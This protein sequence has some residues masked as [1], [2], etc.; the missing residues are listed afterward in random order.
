MAT[1][2]ASQ[3]LA[4]Q[5]NAFQRF[6]LAFQATASTAQSFNWWPLLTP[7]LYGVVGGAT[8][9]YFSE[10]LGF[11]DGDPWAEDK[12]AKGKKKKK[13]KTKKGS[14]KKKKGTGKKM[15]LEGEAVEDEEEDRVEAEGEDGVEE[16]LAAAAVVEAKAMAVRCA[17]SES[18]G[19]LGTPTHT[20]TLSRPRPPPA[21]LQAA[22]AKAI[23]EEEKK[24]DRFAKRL[25]VDRKKFNDLVNQMGDAESNRRIAQGIK[26][27]DYMIPVVLVALLVYFLSVDYGIT[28]GHWW[29]LVEYYLPREAAV[30]NAFLGR[31]NMVTD[32]AIAQLK[33]DMAAQQSAAKAALD[34]A[35]LGAAAGAGA[36]GAG[37]AAAAAATAAGVAI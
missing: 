22:K 36:G 5:S 15:K 30:I 6:A 4:A 18:P 17:L 28:A 20:R 9:I 32:E 7:L 23:A 35:R 10:A 16:S 31:P 1:T 13:K 2:A 3:F 19:Q 37:A 24:K 21:P 11:T 27:C 14:T 33:R 8:L 25:G 26:F 12:K 29:F 34:A